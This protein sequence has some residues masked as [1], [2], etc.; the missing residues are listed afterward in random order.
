MST[1]YPVSVY[2]RIEQAVSE[3]IMSLRKLHGQ[4]V[5]AAGRALQHEFNNDGLLPVRVRTAARR[6]D[7]FRP[8]D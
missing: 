8:R 2:R 4:F 5:V 3:R 1:V 6:L 7:Q